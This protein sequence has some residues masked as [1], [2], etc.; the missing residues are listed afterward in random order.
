MTLVGHP[1]RHYRIA[2]STNERARELAA[3]GAVGGTVVTATE[4]SAGRGRYGRSWEAPPGKALLYSVIL[5]PPAG[6]HSLLSLL[7]AVAVAEAIESV[8]PVR[9]EI[10]WPNDVWIEERKVAGI[11]IEARPPHWTVVGIGINVSIEP[12]EFPDDLRWPATSIGHGAT[13]KRLLMAVNGSLS[14]WLTGE[15]D[16]V[17][18]AYRSRDGLIGRLVEWTRWEAD[19]PVVGTADGVDDSGNLLVRDG[20]RLVAVASGEVRM[21]RKSVG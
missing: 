13:V 6:E 2:D 1:H 8:A 20:D 3:T 12:G 10:K 19:V 11:L 7:V 17:L 4:Q 15:Q 14:A 5:R 16:A 9:C 21:L 18:G